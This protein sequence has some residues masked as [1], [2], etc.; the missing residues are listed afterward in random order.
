M[1]CSDES[2]RIV[3]V[4]NCVPSIYVSNVTLC[5]VKVGKLRWG[6]APSQI[7]MIKITFKSLACMAGV[8]AYGAIFHT[9]NI[10]NWC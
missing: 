6:S 3:D 4:L 10:G 8:A 1:S 5:M 2:N 9:T 7:Q